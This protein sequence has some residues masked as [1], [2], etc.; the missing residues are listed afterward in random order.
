MREMRAALYARVACATQQTKHAI[1][2]QLEML[3]DYAASRG[4]KIIEEFTDEGPSGLRLD[5][6]GLDRMRGLAERRGIDVLLTCGPDRLARSF[7]LQVLIIEELERCGVRTMF[8]DRGPA[9]EPLSTLREITGA[10]AELEPS[11]VT[12]RDRHGNRHRAC[13][14]EMVSAELPFGY[15]RIPG[16]ESTASHVEIRGGEAAVMRKIFDGRS[17]LRIHERNDSV[18]AASRG[19]GQRDF[20]SSKQKVE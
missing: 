12:E 20:H 5:R 1:V 3:R 14:Q 6:P 8:L 19:R 7:A 11:K 17:R 15:G 2:S 16:R 18:D 9:D 10:V 4:M 13:C